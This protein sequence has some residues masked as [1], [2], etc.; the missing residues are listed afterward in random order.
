M[1]KKD[2]NIYL[3]KIMITVFFYILLSLNF[4]SQNSFQIRHIMLL[5]P[6]VFIHIIH[7]ITA[8]VTPL[9]YRNSIDLFRFPCLVPQKIIHYNKGYAT[10]TNIPIRCTIQA[11]TQAI[12]HCIRAV[13][14]AAFTVPISRR[15]V[16]IAATHGV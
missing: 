4:T 1:N 13:P 6:C 9:F 7:T 15:T 16:A 8:S 2:C 5:F 3:T 14:T 12:P 10:P 11:T